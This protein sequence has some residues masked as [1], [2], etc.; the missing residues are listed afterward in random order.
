MLINF[1][2]IQINSL[3]NR[4]T[5]LAEVMAKICP[6]N[7][8]LVPSPKGIDIK[9]MDDGGVVMMDTCNTAQKKRRILCDMI[10][11]S[12]ELDCMNHLQNVWFRNVEKALSAFLNAMLQVDLDEIDPSYGSLPPS[13]PSSVQLIRSSAF[14]QTTPKDMENYFVNG[15]ASTILASYSCMLNVQLDQGKIYVRKAF[16]NYPFYIEFLDSALRK[17]RKTNNESASILQKNLFVVLTSS[18]MLALVRLLS[19]LHLSIVMPF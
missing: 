18:E 8:H 10:V 16:I 11:G 17:P 14:P 3:K 4:L 2:F 15:F 13:V 1:T 9:K 6:D 5:R 12:Y 7:V 19:I